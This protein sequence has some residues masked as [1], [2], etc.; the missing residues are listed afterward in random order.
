MCIRDSNNGGAFEEGQW[1][2][3]VAPGINFKF[4]YDTMP[5]VLI[6]QADGNFRFARV[7]GRSYAVTHSTSGTYSQSGTTVTVTSNGHGLA[8]G[9]LVDAK[10]TSGLGVDGTFAITSVTTN[11]FVYTAVDSLTTSGNV[12]YGVP[13]YTLPIWGERICGD[14]N[15]S[16]NPSFI[17]NKINNVFFFRNRLGFLANDNVI[18]STVSKFF[19]FFP[20]TVLTVIDSDPIDVAASH[21]KVAILKNAINLSLI[22]I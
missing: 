11:T 10:I 2:E 1:Q 6:R 19:T 14:L 18:L 13:N 15:S 8:V 17:G 20:E 22:H 21:T 7:D 3:T 12:S 9:S 4:N 16:L 5:H